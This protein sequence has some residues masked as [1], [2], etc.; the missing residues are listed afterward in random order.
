MNKYQRIVLACGTVVVL[1]MLL[2]PP[3]LIKVNSERAINMGYAFILTPPA[4]EMTYSSYIGSVNGK[5]LLIQWIGVL[6]V[7]SL[8]YLLLS[9]KER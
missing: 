3:F 2:F 9:S 5:L 7:A 1:L 8:G 6:I 4:R